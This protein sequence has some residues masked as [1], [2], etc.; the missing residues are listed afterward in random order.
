MCPHADAGWT[1]LDADGDIDLHDAALFAVLFGRQYFDYGPH[2]EDAEA[3][4]LAMPLTQ[5]L[6][7]PDYEYERVHRDLGLI[8]EAY[9]D[10]SGVVDTPGIAGSALWVRLV[11][12]EDRDGFDEM[13]AFFVV[14]SD[15]EFG[16]SPGL[17]GLHFC[18]NLNTPI[19]ALVYEQLD[20]VEY[21]HTSG[22]LC[23]DDGC[24]CQ[25]IDVTRFDNLFR[26]AFYYLSGLSPQ[27][28]V[29]YQ[30]RTLETDEAG[31]VS[32]VGCSDT[33]LGGCP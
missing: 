30:T 7:V 1:D 5:E 15:H 26:Y 9:P 22:A 2:R 11:S 31:A 13:N 4:R 32:L 3:E 23:L 33:C 28:G 6:R 14:T 19:L 8:R 16:F 20:E 18:D 24:C 12:P 10:L 25:Q 27:G 29:C 21:A 17:H